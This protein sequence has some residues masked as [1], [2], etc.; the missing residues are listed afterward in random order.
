MYGNN[1]R[2][3]WNTPVPL[4]VFD[5][6][7]EKGGLKIIQRGGGGQTRSLRL[8]AQDGHQYVLR[9]VNKYPERNLPPPLASSLV[10]EVVSDQTSAAHPYGALVLAPLAEA[11]GVH[12]TNPEIVYVPDDPRLGEH[13]DFMGGAVALFEERPDDDWSHAAYFG[14]SEDIESTAKLLE[15]LQE[16]NDN[17]VDAQAYLRA[18]LLD[19][20]VGDWDRHEDNWRWASFDKEK[21]RRFEPIPRDRDQVFYVNEGVL[22]WVASQ[23]FI[24]PTF[25]GFDETIRNVNTWS[26]QSQDLDRLLLNRLSRSDWQATAQQ[27]QQQLTDEVIREAIY[28]L[29][30]TLVTLT[31]ADIVRKLRRRR[32]DL[33]RYAEEYYVFLARQV[34]VVGS[35]KHELFQIERLP[36]HRTQITVEKIKKDGERTGDVTFQRTFLGSETQELRLFGLGGQDRDRKSVV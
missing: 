12:H 3:A 35:D 18:R 20:V 2:K 19:V 16:D 23:D 28:Q 5:I 13:Q 25:Q 26:G 21:G 30:D 11:V 9:S 33:P 10:V 8:E 4:R 7:R 34:N 15:E 1:Y 27:M 36:D 24:L 22:H 17:E 29:P 14:H 31:G 6:D 32:D